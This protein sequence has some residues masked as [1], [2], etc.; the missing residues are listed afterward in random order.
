MLG[1]A[2]TIA[3][4]ALLIALAVPACGGETAGELVTIEVAIRSEPSEGG[5][6]TRFETDT[7]YAVEL[8]DAHVRIG[9]I[10]AFAPEPMARLER[11]PWGRLRGSFV[12]VAR[13]HG[14]VDL[15]SGRTVRAEW[16]EPV[17]LDA[18]DTDAVVLGEVQAE[19]GLVDAITLEL[20]REGGDGPQ[21]IVG[22]DA[23]RA[24]EV[25]RFEGAVLLGDEALD[26]RVE[27]VH[28]HIELTEGGRLTL[29]VHP[30]VWLRDAE[31]AR[32]PV[33]DGASRLTSDTQ[34]GR[35]L[36]IGVRSPAA[37]SLEWRP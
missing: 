11:S 36:Q 14:G 1:T 21:V 13:A 34:P 33:Q 19:R 37:F 29:V 28:E 24:G 4:R 17:T 32:A 8:E 12:S 31:F 25:V 6:V 35:A 23:A 7:G 22:G 30:D 5:S 20:A 27:L 26:R 2:R 15:I 16:L 18:L 10:F 3:C 9:P